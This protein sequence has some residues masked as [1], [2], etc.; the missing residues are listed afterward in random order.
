[1]LFVEIKELY[2]TTDITDIYVCAV[3]GVLKGNITTTEEH[4]III[5][6]FAGQVQAGEANA[7]RD[8]IGEGETE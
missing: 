4:C 1:M 2:D 6:F 7:I 8:I 3:N 5:P